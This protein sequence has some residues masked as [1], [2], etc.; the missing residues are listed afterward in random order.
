MGLLRGLL[1][2]GVV[3]AVMLGAYALVPAG[4]EVEIGIA[5]SKFV[6][7]ALSVPA[8]TPITFVLRNEDP[9]DHEWIVGDDAT[10][11]RHRTGTEPHHDERATEQSVPALG[12]VRTTVT[13]AAPGTYRMICHLPG[14][15]AY[16][17][18]GTITVTR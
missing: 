16:G 11:Q 12:D 3:A 8:G 9:I 4:R 6:P 5:Y 14:H 17:M 13:F 15:E 10:H 2:P 18:V 7:A 1:V